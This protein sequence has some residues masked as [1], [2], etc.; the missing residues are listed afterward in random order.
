MAKAISQN[1]TPEYRIPSALTRFAGF[2]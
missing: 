1:T 2:T